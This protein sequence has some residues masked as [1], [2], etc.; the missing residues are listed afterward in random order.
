MSSRVVPSHLMGFRSMPM[1]YQKQYNCQVR[2]HCVVASAA[3]DTGA[4][5]PG[6]APVRQFDNHDR[7]ET[8]CTDRAHDH[9]GT[10]AYGAGPSLHRGTDNPYAP[11]P[12]VVVEP[13]GR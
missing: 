13:S 4:D 7:I 1:L 12:R 2:S 11:G 5:A 3:R 9:T 6:M 8:P 10:G